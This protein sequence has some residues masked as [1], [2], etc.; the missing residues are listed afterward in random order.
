[1]TYDRL[2][3]GSE[4]ILYL[5][6]HQHTPSFAAGQMGQSTQPQEASIESGSQRRRWSGRSYE[7]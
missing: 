5:V 2:W 3:M 6:A 7:G 1:M 4:E